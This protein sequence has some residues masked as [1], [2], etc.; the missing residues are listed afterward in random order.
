MTKKD[1]SGE[2]TEENG[3]ITRGKCG[4]TRGKNS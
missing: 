4:K 3:R 1:R 2:E